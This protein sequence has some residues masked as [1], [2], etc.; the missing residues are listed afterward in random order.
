M[1]DP[2]R[3]FLDSVRLVRHGEL[4]LRAELIDFRDKDGAAE[5]YVHFV[6]TDR[7][8]DE[9]VDVDRVDLTD[10]GLPRDDVSPR[11]RCL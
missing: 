3:E 7:R 4:T 11:L 1:E 5:F 10:T 6:G 9:W 2:K 8:N